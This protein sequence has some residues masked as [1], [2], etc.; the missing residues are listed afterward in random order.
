MARGQKID[1][2]YISLGLD[3]AHLQLD[4]DTAGKTVSQTIAR[5]NSKNNQIK[6]RM[7]ADLSKLE[8]V[9]SALDKIR[10]KQEAIN[11]QLDLQR[12]KE[13]ILANVLKEAQK[14]RSNSGLTQ[15]AQTNLLRQQKQVAALEAELRKLNK[16]Y[17]NAGGNASAFGKGFY[18]SMKAAKNGISQLTSGMSLLSAKTAA[19]MTIM[20]TGAGLF[21][22]TRNAMQA[23][24]EIG[25][26]HV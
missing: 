9:G 6:L 7:D 17:K 1:E 8:G 24:E 14:T 19:V 15:N 16:A 10:T 12:K 21:T 22:L 20:T 5:L 3:V 2:L 4:F 26:A 25:R 18:T 13:E 23:G 11:K